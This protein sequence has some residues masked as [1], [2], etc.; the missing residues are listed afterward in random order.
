MRRRYMIRVRDVLADAEHW[1]IDSQGETVWVEDRL[2]ADLMALAVTAPAEGRLG[3]V[4]KVDTDSCG[5][6]LSMDTM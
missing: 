2:P 4:V 6:V 5:E 1:L 3:V